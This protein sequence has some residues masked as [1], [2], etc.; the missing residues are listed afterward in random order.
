M[1]DI[2][3]QEILIGNMIVFNPPTYKG[4]TTG[5]VVGFTPKMVRVEFARHYHKP[6]ETSTTTV[7]PTDV[8]VVDAQLE[9]M[10]KLR[11]GK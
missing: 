3:G 1:N 7:Y 9:F 6:G 5:K 4:L 2:V 11:G 8:M 10:Y